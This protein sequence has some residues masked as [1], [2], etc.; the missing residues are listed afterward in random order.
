MDQDSFGGFL[1]AYWSPEE[2]R[3][4]ATIMFNL[5][6][7]LALGL[8]VGYE[9]SYHGRA[10][11]MR[12]Y[13]L[14]CT[15]SAALTILAGYPEQWFGGHIAIAADVDPTRVVQGIVTGIGFLGAGVIMRLGFNISG[16]T[17][18][19][20][21]WLVAAVGVLVGV[22]FYGA[23]VLLAIL[24]IICLTTVARLEKWLPNRQAIAVVVR[25]A[26]GF[27]PDLERLRQTIAA[28]RHALAMGT[29]CVDYKNGQTEWSFVAVALGRQTST[30]L[31]ALSDGISGLAGIEGFT[32]SHARN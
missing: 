29:L 23:A 12:T 9:R 13:G 24:A 14:V 10:A 7:A 4:N 19:A 25:F 21:I 3:V 32:L 30:S 15:T 5:I 2:V 20:S 16:L 17:T 1:A 18:A 26:P 11:G 27:N 28:H 31:L 6:F 22:G 8:L